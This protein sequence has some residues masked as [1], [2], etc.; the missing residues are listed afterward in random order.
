MMRRHSWRS[1][2][3]VLVCQKYHNFFFHVTEH[4]FAGPHSALSREDS[5]A[6]A[7]VLPGAELFDSEFPF[8][9]HAAALFKSSLAV[10]HEVLFSQLALSVAPTGTDTTALWSSIITGNADLGLYDDA[11]AS[12]ISTPHEQL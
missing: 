11:Y 10:Q 4:I 9:L 3:V 2:Q 8:Y 12:L 6:L 1:S 7:I 5:E